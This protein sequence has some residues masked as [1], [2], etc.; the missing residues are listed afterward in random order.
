V[1]HSGKT[2]VH[3]SVQELKMANILILLIITQSKNMAIYSLDKSE[4]NKE[5]L[6]TGRLDLNHECKLNLKS[7]VST[8]MYQA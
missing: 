1:Q 3:A 4:T 7:L 5:I 8:G 2:S 6:K